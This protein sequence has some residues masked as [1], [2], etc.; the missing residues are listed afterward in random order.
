MNKLDDNAFAKEEINSLPI[1]WEHTTIGN[2][3]NVSTG[4]AFKSKN[5]SDSGKLRVVRGENVSLKKLRWDKVKYWNHST[6]G[7]ENYILD[8]YDI[9]IG[10]DGSRIGKNKS[11]IYPS[12]LPL[13][14]AQRVARVKSKDGISQSFLKYSI[15]NDIFE[16]YIIKVQTGTSIP[17]ISLGQIRAFE[18]NIPK[19]LMEQNAIAKLLNSFDDKI[20]LLQAQNKTLESL[21]QTLF[22]NWFGKYQVDDEL[23]EGWKIKTIEELVEIIIDYRGKTPKKLGMDWSVSGIPALSAKTIK[24]GKIV[25]RD[26]MNFGSQAL[27]DIW[28][29][30]ELQKGDILLTSEAPLGEM[31]YINDD[32]KYILSQRLF[33]LRVN[34]EITSQYLYH[35]L[36]SRYGQHL[37]Q[38]RASGSTVEG[39]RQSE[40]RKI[41]VVVPDEVALNKASVLFQDIFDKKHNNSKQI[42]SLK[43]T[44]DELLPKLMSGKIRI[45]EFVK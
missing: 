45:K 29:K 35:Y 18:I 6:S 25:R 38:A 23:P 17:H 30:D 13:I 39:I 2:V 40:L 14:L 21:S 7:L 27:Y 24:K 41:E 10:M 5:Y 3:A 20:E 37:L 34:N 32:K 16:N 11:S 31:Y 12:E 26:A 33:A 44:R 42:Q 43:K 4:F 19:D 9:V 36:F 15:L 28:M 8:A 22:K 1:G